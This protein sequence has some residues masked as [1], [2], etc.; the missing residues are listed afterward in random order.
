MVGQIIP[1]L[2]GVSDAGTKSVNYVEIVPLLL[3]EIQKLTARID[4][5]EAK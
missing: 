2:I 5:L 3:A 1:A 4:A